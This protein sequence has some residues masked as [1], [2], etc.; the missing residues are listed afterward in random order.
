[1]NRTHIGWGIVDIRGREGFHED[2]LLKLRDR[3]L[4]GKS[5]TSNLMMISLPEVETLRSLKLVVGSKIILKYRLQF[6]TRVSRRRKSPDKPP[7]GMHRQ[8]AMRIC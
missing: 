6:S 5:E 7:S 4:S 8:S 2:V 3:Y 1:M